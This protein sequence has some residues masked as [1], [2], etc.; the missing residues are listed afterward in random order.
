MTSE[1]DTLSVG[2][3]RLRLHGRRPLPGVA[4]RAPLLRPAP[5]AR[6]SG[7]GRPRRGEGRGSR[8]AAR[9]GRRPR[10][11]GR[12]WSTAT[13]STWS[14]SAPPATPTPRSR[15]PRSRPASTC[16]ARS[17]WPTPSRRPR[18]WSRRPRRRAPRGVRS[19]VGFT[20]RRV[21]AIGLARRL[22]AEGRIG[23]DPPRPGAVPPGLDR[24][25]RGAA[26]VA[27]ATRTKAGSGALGD[28]GAHI[29]DLTQFI[30]GDTIATVSGT[31]ETFV[32]ERPLP[33]EH[34]RPVRHRGHR[35]RPGH[36]R[37]RGRCSWPASAAARSA[38][39]RRPASPT[40]ART[41]SASRSTGRAAASRSTSRT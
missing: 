25:P 24:R 22:V 18:R 32:K 15:S 12:R 1:Q 39:S 14:T 23:D 20:Y 8:R 30:T 19:M 27:A 2:H 6:M 38:S 4:H 16:C 40:A 17:R 7:G 11:R 10:R 5:A 28:I 34:H 36:R 41:P 31:L 26:V 9:L 37:R 21:P 3:G 29:V 33:A 13:T 35:A